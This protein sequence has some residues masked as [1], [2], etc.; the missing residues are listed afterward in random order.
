M[1]N[2]YCCMCTAGQTYS[3]FSRHI[4]LL[5]DSWLQRPQALVCC[6]L[7]SQRSSL[8]Y[9]PLSFFLCG[10]HLCSLCIICRSLSMHRSI[11]FSIVE[12]TKLSGRSSCCGEN[13]AGR[14]F[15]WISL[16]LYLSWRF[17]LEAGLAVALHGDQHII[18]LFNA[19]LFASSCPGACTLH[20][21][22]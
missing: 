15:L 9:V 4:V 3:A 7:R 16:L 5:M 17:F 20:F 21:V 14:C 10:I 2:Y 19:M 6:S 22:C 13:S 1:E 18:F 12:I 8:Q 11:L